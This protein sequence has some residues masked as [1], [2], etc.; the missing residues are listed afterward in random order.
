MFEKMTSEVA[1]Q[2]AGATAYSKGAIMQ[3][4]GRGSFM[5]YEFADR[6]IELRKE[7]GMSQEELAA[8][9]SL[10]RQAISKWERAE[11]SPD[12]GNLVALSEVY[13]VTIDEIVRGKETGEEETGEK[14]VE[15]TAEASDEKTIGGASGDNNEGV[16]EKA[17]EEAAKADDDAADAAGVVVEVAAAKETS[18]TDV[19]TPP[20]PAANQRVDWHSFHEVHDAQAARRSQASQQTPP[21]PP[22]AQGGPYIHAPSTAAT[23]KPRKSPMLTFP[24]PVLCAVLFLLAGFMFGW[25]HPAWI[26][27]LTIPFYYWVVN[28]IIDDPEY[29]ARHGQ[30]GR[31]DG[32]N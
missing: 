3:T 12:I 24:Y 19:T 20:P 1:L 9:I 21:P 11:S 18:S 8:R 13:G 26:I 29:Q 27:F 15:E 30:S 4:S 23:E 2:Q 25:W 16:A 14:T 7:H 28:L 5:S 22:H 6:L 17:I 32:G 10:S 31:A